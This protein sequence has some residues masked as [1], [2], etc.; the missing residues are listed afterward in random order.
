MTIETLARAALRLFAV[1]L[2]VSALAEVTRT[3]SVFGRPPDQMAI[4]GTYLALAAVYC[5][6]AVA[7]WKWSS[8]VARRIAGDTPG[9]AATLDGV[10]PLI[11]G[12]L[13]VGLLGVFVL[14]SAIPDSLW[15]LAVF[16]AS[17]VLGPS[18][19][20]GQ[21]AYDAQMGLYTVGGVANAVAILA[22][23]ALGLFLVFR[24]RWAAAL[25]TNETS[26]HIQ[27]PQ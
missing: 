27:A 18:P 22:R 5:G 12:Q 24:A 14:S 2:S 25:L 7:L 1:W 10:T 13:T 23:L 19:L 4:L 8:L 17:R 21:P 15:I 20:A 16:G 26:V 9:T 11:L 3:F 6:T